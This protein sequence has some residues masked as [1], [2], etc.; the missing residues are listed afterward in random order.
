M[1]LLH[2][3]G[4]EIPLL[5]PTPPHMPA[6]AAV[7]VMLLLAVLRAVAAE[8]GAQVPDRAA[9]AGAQ[10]CLEAV[11]NPV[12]GHAECVNP[13]GAAVEQPQRQDVPCTPPQT[14]CMPK[15][16]DASKPKH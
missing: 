1:C 5:M 6:L 7:L 2:C 11:V 9:P 16:A 14:H 4:I 12:S 15:S 8:P 3:A 10:R 13:P